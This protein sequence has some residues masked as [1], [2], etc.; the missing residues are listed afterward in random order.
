MVKTSTVESAANTGTSDRTRAV[1]GG[2]LW[3]LAIVQYFLAQ[4][5]VAAAWSTPYSLQDNYISDLG[6]T[7]CGMFA[8]PHGQPTYVCS[9][10]HGLMNLSFITLGVLAIAGAILLRRFGPTGRMAS[11]A[12]Y[13]WV[14]SGLGKILVGLVPENT[15]ITAHLVGAF[16]IP[17]A[18]V[19]ILLFSLAVRRS[20]VPLSTFGIVVAVVGLAG[21][22]LSTVGQYAGTGL[23]LGFGVGGMERV[24]SY[25]G[26]LWTLVVG[27]LAM[28]LAGRT[29]P[30][31]LADRTVPPG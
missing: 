7:D 21:T 10:S 8:L 26:S 14:I 6:N 3:V 17:V 9:P 19:A 4:L 20:N 15:T 1:V 22:V 28:T 31:P 23:Y 5:V 27:A 2:L 29:D 12:F 30:A 11:T 18:S 25:P 24:A 13:L 16:N